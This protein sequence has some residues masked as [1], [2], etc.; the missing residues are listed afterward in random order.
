MQGHCML[1]PPARDPGAV[2]SGQL[3]TQ[4]LLFCY[5]SFLRKVLVQQHETHG[6]EY[7]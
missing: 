3:L 1:S 4:L 6:Y 5:A 2:G 7:S